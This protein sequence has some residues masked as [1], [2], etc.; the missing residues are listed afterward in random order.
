MTEEEVDLVAEEFAKIGGISWYPGREP[1]PLVRVVSDRYRERARAAIA[2][3]DQFRADGGASATS[4][5][6]DISTTAAYPLN[7]VE[8]ESLKPGVTIVYRPKD[9]PRAYVCTVDRI[10]NGQVRLIPHGVR[11][12]GW[13]PIETVHPATEPD[14]PASHGNEA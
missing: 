1:G 4:T 11:G 2:A 3:L 7:A 10:E 12:I 6:S 8:S 9:D 13:V 5:S 14:L